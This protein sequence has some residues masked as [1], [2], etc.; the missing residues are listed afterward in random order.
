[1]Y[2]LNNPCRSGPIRGKKRHLARIFCSLIEY[3]DRFTPRGVLSIIDFAQI[4][5]LPFPS[6]CPCAHTLHDAPTAVL[7]AIL[8]PG[9]T[10]QIHAPILQ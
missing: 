6:A 3:A 5:Q 4:Q 2:G 7:F 9:A 10:F 1:M 8:F